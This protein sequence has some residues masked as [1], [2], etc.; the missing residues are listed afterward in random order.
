MIVTLANAYVWA[1]EIWWTDDTRFPFLHTGYA[2]LYSRESGETVVALRSDAAS[3]G[4][5]AARSVRRLIEEEAGVQPDDTTQEKIEKLGR[6]LLRRLDDKR[7]TPDA[8]LKY[9]SP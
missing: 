9:A 6:F 8:S 2:A 3:P 5:E 7:G 4:D 1:Y